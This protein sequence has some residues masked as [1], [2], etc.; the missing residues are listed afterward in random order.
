MRDLLQFSDPHRGEAVEID[1]VHEVQATLDL[2]AEDLRREDIEVN[3]DLPAA[4]AQVGIDPTRLRQLLLNLLTF[5]QHRAGKNGI[6]NVE[7]A[8]C[9]AG[10]ELMVGNSGPLLGAEQQ[11]KAFEPFQAPAETGSGLGLALVQVHVEEAGGRVGWDGP[12]GCIDQ[13]GRD[14]ETPSSNRIRIWLPLVN[15]AQKGVAS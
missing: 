10:V 13:F 6:I 2:L 15:N 8:P 14:G 9:G 5:A 3:V 1:L 11:A 12:N 4:P 7:L